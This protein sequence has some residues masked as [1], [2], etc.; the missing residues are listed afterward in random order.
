MDRERERERERERS[1]FQTRLAS[2]LSINTAS[3]QLYAPE[4]IANCKLIL[5]V[6][7][8]TC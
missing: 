5:S 7:V 1:N 2:T 4:M 8:I 3:R 6:H